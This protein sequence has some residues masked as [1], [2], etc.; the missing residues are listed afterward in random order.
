MYNTFM[1][2]WLIACTNPK[3]TLE[4]QVPLPNEPPQIDLQYTPV[5]TKQ[6]VKENT[7]QLLSYGVPNPM[8]IMN[9]YQ[10]LYDEG[11]TSSCPGTDYNFDGSEIST[12]GCTTSNGFFFAGSAEV[13]WTDDTNWD[14]HCDCRIVSPDGRTF[15]GAGNLRVAE[16]IIN[17]SIEKFSDIRGSFIVT[18]GS[19]WLQR[20]PSTS[21]QI[22]FYNNYFSVNG[23]YSINA[24][25]IYFDNLEFRDCPNGIGTSHIRDPSGGW[26]TWHQDF[27]CQEAVSFNDID[28]GKL[29]VDLSEFQNQLNSIMATQ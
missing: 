17:N 27:N 25:S 26:W 16:E 24:K 7:E 5:W 22:N 10:S 14:F 20:S 13:R 23:G 19:D 12:T 6:E 8:E 11:A 28:Y 21:F 2:S 29:N 4:E 1:L 9:A 15:R 3:S 18:D